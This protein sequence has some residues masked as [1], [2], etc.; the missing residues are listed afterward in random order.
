MEYKLFFTALMCNRLCSKFM[1]MCDL[2]VEDVGVEVVMSFVTPTKPTKEYIDKIIKTLES[3]KNY[4]EL[5]KYFVNVKL[6]RIEVVAD[7][8][9]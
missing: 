8:L 1:K 2:G 9:N 6:D 5:E 4:K 7:E 3:T